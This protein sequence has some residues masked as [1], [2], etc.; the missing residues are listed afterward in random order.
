MDYRWLENADNPAPGNDFIAC[1][2]SCTMLVQARVVRCTIGPDVFSGHLLPGNLRAV[3]PCGVP[4]L[5]SAFAGL[6]SR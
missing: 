3:L 6:I 2:D 4:D 5:F 1:K